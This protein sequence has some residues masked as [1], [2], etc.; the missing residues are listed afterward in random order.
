VD[1]ELDARELFHSML[2]HYGAEVKA[3]ASSAE[4]LR[5]IDEWRPD[6]L[7]A[8]IGMPREDGYEFMKKVRARE[9]ERGGRIPV[10]A[11]TAYAGARDER[12]ALAVGYQMYVSKPVESGQLAATVASLAGRVRE[13]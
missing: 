10:V 12:K 11:V 7:V 13:D 5:T 4:A 1:D 6:V 8:D 9:P 3:C 2:T